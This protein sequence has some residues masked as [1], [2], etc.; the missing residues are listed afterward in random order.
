MSLGRD[1]ICTPALAFSRVYALTSLISSPFKALFD[2]EN[3]SEHLQSRT[4]AGKQPTPPSHHVTTAIHN[5]GNVM[6]FEPN[7]K[8]L[9]TAP[10][11]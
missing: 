6:H 5:N 9:A 8:I 4:S 1:L 3:D 11:R 7:E 10:H 2:R